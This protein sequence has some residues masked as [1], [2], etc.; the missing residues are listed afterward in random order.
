MIDV[1]SF[2]Q[3]SH[4][5]AYLSVLTANPGAFAELLEIL[6]DPMNERCLIVVSELGH[7]ALCGVVT[8]VEASPAL[9]AVVP[10]NLRFRQAVGVAVRLRMEELGWNTTGRKLSVTNS[11]HFKTAE[12]YSQ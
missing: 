9:A 2:E 5:A 8:L 12:V 1:Q 11:T 4:A 6:N 7:P 10:D 3:D